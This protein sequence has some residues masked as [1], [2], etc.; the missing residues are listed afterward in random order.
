MSILKKAILAHQ[1]EEMNIK[2]IQTFKLSSAS[3][4]L[5]SWLV[6]IS[7]SKLCDTIV[8]MGTDID[9][10]FFFL[11]GQIYTKMVSSGV[12]FFSKNGLQSSS[13][14]KTC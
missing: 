7:D 13:I 4:S 9:M 5:S 6:Y 10:V 12:A 3:S 8:F 2:K 14:C 1:S 11:I